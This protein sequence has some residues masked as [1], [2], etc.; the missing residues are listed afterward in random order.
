MSVHMID[1]CL[2]NSLRNIDECHISK[3]C[4][5]T[6]LNMLNRTTNDIYLWM[7]NT[8]RHLHLQIYP[9][10]GSK[11]IISC[12][13]PEWNFNLTQQ[14][15]RATFGQ[16]KTSP[17]N[18]HWMTFIVREKQPSVISVIR[19]SCETKL[20]IIE[21]HWIVKYIIPVWPQ[22]CKY[23]MAPPHWLTRTCWTSLL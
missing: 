22:H 14:P 5:V 9:H 7:Q 18:F 13:F 11:Y 21:T 16:R 2:W 17:L 4:P 19:I 20:Q 23:M 3:S 10:I 15:L 6:S 12:L 8:S 1:L